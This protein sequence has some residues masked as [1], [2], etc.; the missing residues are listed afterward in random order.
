MTVKL[1][2]FNNLHF[3][4]NDK[5]I[6]SALDNAERI[7]T[8]YPHPKL[9]KGSDY[10]WKYY[11]GKVLLIVD[12]LDIS[13]GAIGSFVIDNGFGG[14]S[15]LTN[16]T[17][18]I[19][20]DRKTALGSDW[21][22]H[23]L[24]NPHSN[25]ILYFV[26]LQFKDTITYKVGITKHSVEKRF[27]ELANKDISLLSQTI[28]NRH[29]LECSIIEK[30]LI[31]SNKESLDILPEEMKFAGATECFCDDMYHK[32]TDN[33]LEDALDYLEK[34]KYPI[35]RNMLNLAIKELYE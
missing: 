21:I 26:K 7:G 34:I 18:K 3:Y 24:Y 25:G 15:V 17:P 13:K 12:K 30:Y 1:D 4:I 33:V 23:Y 14:K 2:E 10:A 35:S 19:V 20:I 6:G 22:K 9:P 11:E 29:M 28:V 27:K 32:Y 8:P 16:I 5:L 31:E